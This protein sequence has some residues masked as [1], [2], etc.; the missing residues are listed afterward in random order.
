[1]AFVGDSSVF[2]QGVRDDQLVTA[3]TEAALRER[4]EPTEIFNLSG[5][6]YGTGQQ[7]LLLKQLGPRLRPDAVVL[8]FHP[9]DDLI[10][11]AIGLAGSS[12]VSEAD[13]LRPYLIASDG[14][15]E[16]RYV[17]P[18]RAALRRLSRL[19]AVLESEVL[20]FAAT[21][22]VNWLK[23][24]PPRPGTG[25]RLASGLTPRED[26]EIFQNHDPGDRWEEA[27]QT[28]FGLLRSFRDECNALGAKLLVVVVP[29]VYQVERSAKRIRL[30]IE[31]RIVSRTR[32][33]G[34]ADWNLPERRLAG[35]FA[36]EGIEARP[37]LNSL[38]AAAGTDAP[39]YGLGDQ[40][41]A[42]GHDV[43]ARMVAAWLSGA[44]AETFDTPP[45]GR[46]V[47]TL[48]DPDSAPAL[49]DFATGPL[50]QYLGNG[51][52]RW[53]PQDSGEQWGWVVSRSALV[54]LPAQ[55]RDLLLRGHVPADTAL[56]VVGRVDVAG[57]PTRGFD[58]QE[59]G[60]FDV[61]IS[62]PE[63]GRTV[64]EDGYLVAVLTSSA[65]LVIQQIGFDVD[66]GTEPDEPDP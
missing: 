31:T 10:N 25:Q 19:Y 36:R 23:P 32:L 28:T 41:G 6:D 47:R 40:L 59:V 42:R 39:V 17:Q 33:E 54:A 55:E 50:P 14:R 24:W 7:L 51:W 44:D 45:T 60:P 53:E 16:I 34:Y 52:L 4:G 61:R 21:H 35:F 13:E 56:P 3:R 43:A 26:F 8:F 11:N 46:P 38:R 65:R 58:L 2:A 22:E 57:R 18:V 37:L 27:W 48:A 30:A 49:L 15:L 9:A 12:T 64:T 63:P 1:V 66:S 20:G 62:W 29:S 5:I